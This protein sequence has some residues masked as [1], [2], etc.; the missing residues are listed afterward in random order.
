VLRLQYTTRCTCYS[1]HPLWFQARTDTQETP[2]ANTDTL[3]VSHPS[4]HHPNQMAAPEARGKMR[5]PQLLKPC[6]CNKKPH[7]AAAAATVVL[8]GLRANV[9]L[10]A[11]TRKCTTSSL[12][13]MLDAMLHTYSTGLTVAQPIVA[14]ITMQHA[15]CSMPGC[16][17]NLKLPFPLIRS[18]LHDGALNAQQQPPLCCSNTQRCQVRLAGPEMQ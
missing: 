4:Q 15:G 13:E 1:T 6:S 3:R 12:Q 14:G 11:D 18:P 10:Q 5:P 8:L 16:T 17:C 2:S 9:R 7:H